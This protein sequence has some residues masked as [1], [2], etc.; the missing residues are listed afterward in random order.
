MVKGYGHYHN[1]FAQDWMVESIRFEIFTRKDRV[2]AITAAIMKAAY[3]GSPGD[4]II[5]VYPIEK[6]LNI[7]LRSEATPDHQV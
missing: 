2:D 6:F 3:T 4:G 7:R 1:F 5:A